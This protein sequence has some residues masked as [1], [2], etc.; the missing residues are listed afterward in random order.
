MF[1]GLLMIGTLIEWLVWGAIC[2][3][4]LLGL[5]LRIGE[6][7]HHA[8]SRLWRHPSHAHLAHPHIA[9][10]L[11]AS[12]L[13]AAIWRFPVSAR[14]PGLVVGFTHQPGLRSEHCHPG[15][16]D[17]Y[18]GEYRLSGWPL[19]PPPGNHRRDLHRDAGPGLVPCRAPRGHSERGF[20]TVEGSKMMDR[21]GQ[22]H[23]A[24]ARITISGPVPSW[25]CGMKRVAL[26]GWAAHPA[27]RG[28]E[29]KMPR[30]RKLF[31]ILLSVAVLGA[32]GGTTWYAF[33]RPAGAT[34][35]ATALGHAPGSQRH[36]DGHGDD[37]GHGWGRGE[38][39]LPHPGS[40]GGARGPG[41][42]S[43]QG[44]PGDRPAGA[45]RPPRRG[46]EGP[47]GPSRRRGQARHGQ[48]R[49]PRPGGPD[50]RGRPPPGGGEPSPRPG[51]P[52]PVPAAL[53]GPRHRPPGGGHRRPGL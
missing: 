22:L 35:P 11:L 20:L 37:Q 28:A 30:K 16:R 32:T 36:G 6:A 9:A 53:P 39:G 13:A 21:W 45:G 27:A 12:S 50:G 44:R 3:G 15:D 46:G 7:M 4:L 49:G 2:T 14:G 5:L 47:G 19:D 1:A 24:A 41:G 33:K 31:W 40:G 10:L 51:E 42:G 26:V 8:I 29:G 18:P 25:S 38:G 48:E 43:G 23:L 17:G 52:R 34:G